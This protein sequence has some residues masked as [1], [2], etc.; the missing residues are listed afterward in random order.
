MFNDKIKQKI[1]LMKEKYGA[2]A[3]KASF[4]DEGVTDSDLTD[5]VMLAGTPDLQVFVKIGGCEANRDI[6]KCLRL[7]VAGVVAPMVESEFA[8]SKFI[9]SMKSKCDLLK[10]TPPQQFINIETMTACEKIE[11]ILKEHHKNIDGI[12]VGRSDLSRSLGLSKNNVDDYVVMIYA[13]KAL[14]AAKKYGLKTK[15]GGSVSKKSA[16]RLEEMHKKGLL[17]GFET[18]AVVFDMVSGVS[19]DDAIKQAIEYEQMLLAKREHFHSLKA[20]SFMDRVKKIGE[21]T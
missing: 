14:A 9:S 18:R 6:E 2:S 7:G 16:P 15:M 5:L 19:I 11:D 20:E 13:E 12:V 3:L 4:E 8:V 1:T 21:R 17:D 10:V